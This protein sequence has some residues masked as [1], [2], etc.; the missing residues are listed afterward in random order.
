MI[1]LPHRYFDVKANANAYVGAVMSYFLKSDSPLSLPRET[2]LARLYSADWAELHEPN[3]EHALHE[4][5]KA[6]LGA[7][8]PHSTYLY[9]HYKTLLEADK[10]MVAKA[11]AAQHQQAFAYHGNGAIPYQI[12]VDF[13]LKDKVTLDDWRRIGKPSR[14]RW[15]NLLPSQRNL[16]RMVAIKLGGEPQDYLSVEKEVLWGHINGLCQADLKKNGEGA[17]AMEKPFPSSIY[18]SKIFQAKARNALGLKEEGRMPQ[19]SLWE[20]F[21]IS[22]CVEQLVGNLAQREFFKKGQIA[23][24]PK[25]RKSDKV[26]LPKAEG[27]IHI[28]G[29]FTEG[30]RLKYS[31]SLKLLLITFSKTRN[32]GE[33]VMLPDFAK[34]K[35][36]THPDL[37]KFIRESPNSKNLKPNGNSIYEAFR[38]ETKDAKLPEGTGVARGSMTLTIIATLLGYNPET[39]RLLSAEKEEQKQQALRE[40]RMAAKS[41]YPKNVVLSALQSSSEKRTSDFARLLKEASGEGVL[42]CRGL[43]P[44]VI[45]D[46][47]AEVRAG[48]SIPIALPKKPDRIFREAIGLMGFEILG[49]QKDI[50]I[51]T[52]K[53]AFVQSAGKGPGLVAGMQEQ[54][55]KVMVPEGETVTL[56]VARRVEEKRGASPIEFDNRL[57]P[58]RALIGEISALMGKAE[59]QSDLDALVEVVDNVSAF[60]KFMKKEERYIK[61]GKLAQ[62]HGKL[63]AEISKAHDGKVQGGVSEQFSAENMRV[64]KTR[65]LD[66]IKTAQGRKSLHAENIWFSSSAPAQKR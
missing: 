26:P 61:K 54:D 45:Y 18:S 17:C 42:N 34:A 62:A 6:K 29:R 47:L 21:L 44:Q 58:V 50:A 13:G 66:A 55:V 10:L 48:E 15:E 23:G 64:A 12:L 1:C 36:F 24:E 2:I 37:P 56:L 60:L 57:K 46:N 20:F 16:L 7:D 9:G 40:E 43:S 63:F 14:L 65:I 53:E 28:P 30:A 39:G 59:T 33:F 8:A 38:R 35:F 41:L 31:N 11:G 32:W 52:E 25:A 19:G 4:Y 49:M 5:V 27:Y 3:K 51:L 22:S